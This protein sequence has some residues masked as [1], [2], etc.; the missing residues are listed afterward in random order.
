MGSS[1]NWTA[2]QNKAFEVALAFYDKETPDRW[3]NIAKAVGSGKT[4]EEVKKH[5][6][7]LI[8]DVEH[9][10]SGQVP[11]PKYKKSRVS[12]DGGC[13]MPIDE[14]KRMENLKFQ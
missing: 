10:D 2:K 14:L 13:S 5:Y 7:V 3:H 4:P 8:E 6:E 12:K 11:L 1:S 9:I